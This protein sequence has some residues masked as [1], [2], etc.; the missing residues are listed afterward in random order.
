MKPNIYLDID[1]VLLTSH[2]EPANY[3]HEFLEFVTNNYPTY[4]LT[5]HCNDDAE[6][7][8]KYL[9][10]YLKPETIEFVKKIKP[11]S[12]TTAKTTGIDMSKPFLWFDDY[13]MNYEKQ[14]L[15]EKSLLDNLI[16]VDLNKN[17]DQLKSFVNDFPIPIN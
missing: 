5:T 14:I 8:I 11:T 7:A 4:W 10:V 15:N 1:G 2:V 9:N 6:T 12:W 17:P 13:P 16:V 3:V